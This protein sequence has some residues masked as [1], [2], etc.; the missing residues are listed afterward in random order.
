MSIKGKPKIEK[1]VHGS[2][3]A[4]GFGAASSNIKMYGVPKGG[5][6]VNQNQGS[7]IG[8]PAYSSG[9]GE[10]EYVEPW[11]YYSYYPVT[12]P[13]RRPYSGDP[14]ILDAEEFGEAFDDVEYD[15]NSINAAADLGLMEENVEPSMLFLQLPPTV[16][17]V[18]QS[19]TAADGHNVNGGKTCKLED[20]PGGYMGKM[21]VYKSGAVKLKLGDT[22]FDVSP[23]LDCA[24]AQDVAVVDTTQKHCCAVAEI[25]KHVIV[26]PNVDSIINS[27]AD[28]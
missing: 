14:A 23:G 4:F 21:L 7:S 27:I 18:K 24:F 13:L 19:A 25:D 12:L 26:T 17:M 3:I 10:K 1:K 22:L 15:E 2:Q 11:N 16:P 20:S 28:L 6:S 9:F 5:A 8:G